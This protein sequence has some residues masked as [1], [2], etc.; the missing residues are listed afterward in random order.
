[1]LWPG[2]QA[3]PRTGL[4]HP[5]APVALTAAPSCILKPRAT[6]CEVTDEQQSVCRLELHAL[7]MM[8]QP[9][10]HEKNSSSLITKLYAQRAEPGE[11]QACANIASR[12]FATEAQKNENVTWTK[13]SAVKR[14]E[15]RDICEFKGQAFAG[16]P[17]ALGTEWGTRA[18]PLLLLQEHLSPG[19][20]APCLGP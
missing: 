18:R 11:S 2:R 20:S 16:C 10:Q 3:P 4:P 6:A 12:M 19:S 9:E 5:P 7:T 8:T 13:V 14:S 1:M 15:R 17:Q